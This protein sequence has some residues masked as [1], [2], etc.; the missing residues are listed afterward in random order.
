MNV[1]GW[2]ALV[3][4]ALV[5]LAIIV[6]AVG[7]FM[8]EQI[9]LFS[10]K[11]SKEIEV[12]REDIHEKGELR[13]ARLAKKRAADDKIANKKLDV[14]IETKEEKANEKLNKS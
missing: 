2:I 10:M 11:I 4:L 5:G 1:F 3:V 9:R 13:R 6:Y 8:V 14:Q 7:E 12:M